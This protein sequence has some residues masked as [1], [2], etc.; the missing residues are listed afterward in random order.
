MF[1]WGKSINLRTLF[2]E[3]VQVDLEF[4][5]ACQ[6]K[7]SSM[8]A[9]FLIKDGSRFQMLSLYMGMERLKQRQTILF[10]C[11]PIHSQKSKFQSNNIRQ[12]WGNN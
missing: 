3:R 8:L 12:L 2:K 11:Q 1:Q 6:V 7:I 9:I 5:V 10:I 4:V